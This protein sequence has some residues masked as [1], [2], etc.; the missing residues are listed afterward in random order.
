V[1]GWNPFISRQDA[2]SR[3]PLGCIASPGALPRE[4]FRSLAQSRSVDAIKECLSLEGKRK[5]SARGEYH[6]RTEIGELFAEKGDARVWP[7]DV[8]E[9]PKCMDRPALGEV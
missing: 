4:R 8:R 7:W 3:C 1:K 6:H 9:W 2:P 5:T